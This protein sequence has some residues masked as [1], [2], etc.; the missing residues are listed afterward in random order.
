MLVLGVGVLVG[1]YGAAWVAIKCATPEQLHHFV[2]PWNRDALHLGA[3]WIMSP[4]VVL[5]IGA[6]F[7][8]FGTCY[9]AGKTFGTHRD[10]S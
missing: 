5:A 10:A 8:G 1:W 4:I 7:I 6:I 9:L 2:K 3:L